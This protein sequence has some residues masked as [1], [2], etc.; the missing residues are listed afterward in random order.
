MDT[1]EFLNDEI[2][3]VYEDFEFGNDSRHVYYTLLDDCERAYQ[4]KR[5]I[6]GSDVVNDQVLHHEEDEMFFVTLQKSCN[7]KFI[8][9][10]LAAQITSETRYTSADSSVDPLRL[11]LPRRENIQYTCENHDGYFYILT[12]EGAKNN[13]LFR[14]PIPPVDN[15]QGSLEYVEANQEMVIEHRDFVLIEDFQIRKNHLIVIERSNCLQNIRILDLR[16]DGFTNYHYVGFPEGVYSVWPGSVHEDEANLI[17]AIQYD[18]TIFRF[19]YTSF[20]QPKQVIDYNMDSRTMTVVHEERVGGPIEYDP[21]LYASRRLYA[22]GVDGTAIPISIVFRRDLLGMNMVPAQHNPVLLHSYGAYGSF[23]NPI[24]S[25]SRLSLLDR[26][27]VYA[28]A[29]IRGGADMGNG[30]YEEG[31]LAKKP[32]TFYDFCSAA[33]Y[34][35]KE[36]YTCPEK[37]S[38]YGRSAGGLL[39]GSVINLRPDLFKA[40]LTEVPF[41]DVIN[42]MF[43]TSIPWTAFGILGFI[44]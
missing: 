34:L 3:G 9:V 11:L 21:L 20:I 7:G 42:T 25:A 4:V 14:T 2:E 12:N 40:A 10:K 16:D 13:Y 6:I 36:G 29:H 32:N 1:K 30:W 35:V 28:A 43:D 5:H 41:V 37:L 44:E 17:N 8:F 39:I 24:F 26:G 18:T 33:E 31:K 22:T 38:I 19:T 27:F 23:T 15:G